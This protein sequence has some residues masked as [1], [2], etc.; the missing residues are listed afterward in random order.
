MNVNYQEI[1]YFE[2]WLTLIW[3]AQGIKRL[4]EKLENVDQA[5]KWEYKENYQRE[6]RWKR[7]T[8]MPNAV[9][10]VWTLLKE[11]TKPPQIAQ[12][13]SDELDTQKGC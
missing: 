9:Y 10:L 7:K 8:R 6:L 4:E 3:R 2:Q 11:T 12:R 13:E 1:G 5:E